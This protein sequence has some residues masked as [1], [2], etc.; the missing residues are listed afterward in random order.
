MK[1]TA[2]Q[3]ARRNY[4][5]KMRVWL[6]LCRYCGSDAPDN[7][8]C[9]RCHDRRIEKQQRARVRRKERGVCTVCKAPL[10]DGMKYLCYECNVKK[11]GERKCNT[12]NC[13]NTKRPRQ[14][15]CDE[16]IER[17]EAETQSCNVYFI[18]CRDCNELLT[19]K[20]RAKRICDNC[21]TYKPVERFKKE[22][23]YCGNV[24]DGSYGRRFCTPE[25]CKRYYRSNDSSVPLAYIFKRDF[26]KC[27][28]C[29]NKLK[30]TNVVP[31]PLAPTRDHII[32]LSKGGSDT[33][34]NIQ[35]SCFLCNIRK[36]NRSI[37]GGEQL[38]IFG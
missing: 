6:G 19:V 5:L 30:H 8:L 24:F 23:P 35:L 13:T 37:V 14:V 38:R 20:N 29:G 11:Q 25:C 33:S 7:L 26:G 1:L 28:L 18:R 15:F 32:P 10:E 12:D 9:E 27:Q 17:R 36:G 2:L 31:N 4:I 21:A 3:K 22:C 34:E 16:C